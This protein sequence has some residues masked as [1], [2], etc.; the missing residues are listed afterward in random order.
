MRPWRDRSSAGLAA[1]ACGHRQRWSLLFCLLVCAVLTGCSSDPAEVA[2]LRGR[3]MGTGY[4]VKVSPP[5]DTDTLEK[6]RQR[7]DA[8][9]EQVNR[10]FSTYLPTSELMRFNLNRTTE[11][12]A[13]STELVDLVAIAQSVSEQ[14]AGRYDITVAPLVELWGFGPSGGRD[15]PPSDAE[16]ASVLADVGFHKLAYRRA[17]PALRKSTAAL[18]IDLSSVAKGWAVDRI[19]RLLSDA[20]LANHLVEIGG[21]TRT[22]GRKSD[23]RPWRVAIERPLRDRR[24][25]HAAIQADDMAIA[26]SGDYRN[27]FRHGETFFSHTI[28]PRSGEPFQHRLA[29]V[30]VVSDTCAEADAWATAL[31]ALGEDAGPQLAAAAGIKA[32]F[33][34]RIE[35]ALVEKASPALVESGLWSGD[36]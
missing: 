15:V 9:L 29:S 6:A 21:E 24:Q 17:P 3:T 8:L 31:M 14:T 4:S 18:A 20:G 19:S 36:G 28:D 34:I 5:P 12:Q 33:I 32:L 23:G 25:V 30:T 27:F 10:R 22:R 1:S 2:E 16:I 26:T 7:I 35:G 13:V 11:W